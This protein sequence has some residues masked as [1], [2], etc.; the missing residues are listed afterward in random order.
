M[1][2]HFWAVTLFFFHCPQPNTC[3]H[4]PQDLH[5]YHCVEDHFETLMQC[6]DAQ[7]SRYHLVKPAEIAIQKPLI[8]P[9]SDF[10]RN[11][12]RA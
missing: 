3:P 4:H 11:Y 12:E 6:H 10:R 5:Y 1:A 7:F 8:L 2:S 9:D